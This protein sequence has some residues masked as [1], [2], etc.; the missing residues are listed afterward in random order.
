MTDLDAIRK[1]LADCP[2]P[3]DAQ[4]DWRGTNHYEIISTGGES[5]DSYWWLQCIDLCLDSET[6]DGKRLG[7]VLDYATHYRR[8][9]AALL[10]EIGRLK[11]RR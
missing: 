4:A 5:S 2:I 8:D 10:A 1:R 6:E 11:N 9:V 7:S 3:E